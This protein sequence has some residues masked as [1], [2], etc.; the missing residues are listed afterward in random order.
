MRQEANDNPL[1]RVVG[2]RLHL[3]IGPI[4]DWMWDVHR[5]GLSTKRT[6]LSDRTILKDIAG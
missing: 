4:L 5:I 2:Q 1:K 6:R 3:L